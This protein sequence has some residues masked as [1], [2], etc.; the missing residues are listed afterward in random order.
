MKEYPDGSLLVSDVKA[1]DAGNYTCTTANLH[2]SDAIT[3]SV[4]VQGKAGEEEGVRGE[5]KL[6]LGG[7]VAKK[8]R[9]RQGQREE[10]GGK[11]RG[12]GWS[13]SEETKGKAGEKGGGRGEG[14]GREY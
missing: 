12:I 4:N 3:Y 13:C 11:G 8:R 10:Y 5:G 2:G 6:V 1:R 9:L 14:K 7:V